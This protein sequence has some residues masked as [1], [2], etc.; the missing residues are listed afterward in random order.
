MT[1]TVV[2]EQGAPV[3]HPML[4]VD[5]RGDPHDSPKGK[6]ELRLVPGTH[7]MVINVAGSKA[8]AELVFTVRSGAPTDLGTLKLK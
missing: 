7:V 3:E 6:T 5:R 4:Y 8:R 1:F 2:D